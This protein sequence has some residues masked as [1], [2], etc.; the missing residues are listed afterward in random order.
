MRDLIDRAAEYLRREEGSTRPRRPSGLVSVPVGD[1]GTMVCQ[2]GGG[3][4]DDSY[5]V[6]DD[7]ALVDPEE[8][9]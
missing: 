7:D 6:A 5:I 3:S 2:M 8:V 4:T 9:A 1:D